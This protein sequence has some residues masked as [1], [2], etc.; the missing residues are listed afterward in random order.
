MS[1]KI[2]IACTVVF[3]LS[4][5]VTPAECLADA[6]ELLQQAQTC[7]NSGN[8]Q[9]AEQTYNAV[10]ADYPGTDYALTAKSEITIMSISAKTDSQVQAEIDDLK[11]EF[12]G[13]TDL[14]AVLCNIAAGYAWAGR[15]QQAGNL[16]QQ[17]IRDYPAGSAVAKA[18][19][20]SLRT[21]ILSLIK[22]G[23]Y[24]TAAAE[25]QQLLTSFAGSEY[26][27]AALYHIARNYQWVREFDQAKG[28]LQQ[29]IQLHSQS[30]EAA[31][32]AFDIER[33]DVLLLLKA[34]DFST[35]EAKIEQFS[36]T[37]SANMG[38]P[39][40]VFHFAQEYERQA[41]YEN[42]RNLYQQ[43]STQYPNNHCGQR[44]RFDYP[45][46][47]ILYL[48][49]AAD[50]TTAESRLD[51]FK[52]DFSSNANF[53]KA[54]F[55]IGEEYYK[56]AVFT[57]PNAPQAQA[58]GL[59][60]KAVSAWQ[61]VLQDSES[62]SFTPIACYLAGRCFYR[63]G[64]YENA[65]TCCQRAAADWPDYDH[66]C[67]SLLVAG[68][69]CEKLLD[70][71]EISESQALPEITAAYTQLVENYPGCE[72]GRYAQRWLARNNAQ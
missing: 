58:D 71:G 19:I 3:S 53:T 7:K 59:Y 37:F 51:S 55:N 9:L 14:P 23:D 10:V 31:R 22:S 8:R 50:F 66:A 2:T 68:R 61:T 35:A 49:Q 57:D 12:S 15:Y 16:Y 60:A 43:V 46:T 67:D 6:A 20:G 38:L 28:L 1:P 40:A 54:M 21:D 32:A 36:R 48:I 42:A 72:A 45:R 70:A 17:I 25:V 29:I 47:D 4:F 33:I 44:A 27:P 26:L 24:T 30:P 65:I 34:A 5:C 11:A 18:Q 64:D 63:L 69:S 39:V 41:S 52:A 56:S 62:Y 13:H